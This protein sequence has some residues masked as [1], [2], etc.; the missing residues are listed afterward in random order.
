MQC[1]ALPGLG[2]YALDDLVF[3]IDLQAGPAARAGTLAEA[4]IEQ[5]QERM[6]A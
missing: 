1:F 3:S 4:G 2:G 6:Q 5:A